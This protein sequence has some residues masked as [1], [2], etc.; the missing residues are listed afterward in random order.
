MK[1]SFPFTLCPSHHLSPLLAKMH[2]VAV[3]ANQSCACC[4][5][6]GTVLP[7][8][9]LLPRPKSWSHRMVRIGRCLKDLVPNSC[10]EQG[11]LPLRPG[12]SGL[13]L[14]WLWTFQG[15]ESHAEDT[16]KA[17]FAQGC[18]A[19]V[20]TDAILAQ[21]LI[22][23]PA[24]SPV[25]C[26]SPRSQGEDGRRSRGGKDG[27][28][29]PPASRQ[30]IASLSHA[31]R[32][33]CMAYLPCLCGRAEVKFPPSNTNSSRNYSRVNVPCPAL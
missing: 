25:L 29:R 17:E 12:C 24:Q 30:C 4:H 9:L 27:L 28:G 8:L 10:H 7:S 16:Q 33:P 15:R 23:A 21:K 19:E 3:K 20:C 11:R 13:H 2:S 32:A 26:L 5:S 6:W 22:P 14:S 31:T 18:I 1:F